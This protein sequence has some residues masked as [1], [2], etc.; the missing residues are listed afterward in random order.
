MILLEDAGFDDDG[1]CPEVDTDDEAVLD[2]DVNPD[3]DPEVA[4]AVVAANDDDDDDDDKE[5]LVVDTEDLVF[6]AVDDN[7][8]VVVDDDDTL[9][10]VK[11][12]EGFDSGLEALAVSATVKD[13]FGIILETEE[14]PL[15]CSAFLS[16]LFW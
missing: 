5:E 2:E 13:D 12:A 9:E 8:V 4:C 11:A 7:V 16:L 6:S 1:G 10:E 14:F 3:R 15:P